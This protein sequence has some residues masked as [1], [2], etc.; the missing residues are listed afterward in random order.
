MLIECKSEPNERAYCPACRRK[1]WVCDGH[2]CP[3]YIS[4]KRYD[5]EYNDEYKELEDLFA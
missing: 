5:T 1:Y 4:A 2:E 3:C